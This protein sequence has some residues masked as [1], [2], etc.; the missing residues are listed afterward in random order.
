M[1][2]TDL[3]FKLFDNVD[4]EMSTTKSANKSAHFREHPPTTPAAAAST[5]GATKSELQRDKPSLRVRRV[6]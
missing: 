3:L 2:N 5:A 6:R 4:K 1:A